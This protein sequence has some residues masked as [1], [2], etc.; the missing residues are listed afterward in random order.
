[1]KWRMRHSTKSR[2]NHKLPFKC[3][4]KSRDKLLVRLFKEKQEKEN[5]KSDSTRDEEGDSDGNKGIIMEG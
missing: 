1:M 3:Q 4:K 5:Q 2:Q